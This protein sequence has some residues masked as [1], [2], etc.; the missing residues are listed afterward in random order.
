MTKRL[1]VFALLFIVHC[2]SF[3]AQAAD[4]LRAVALNPVVITGT[5][6]YHRADNSPV[7]VRVI[8]AEELQNAHVTSLQEALSRLT[9]HVTTHTNGMGTFINFNGIS[10]DYIVILE[11]GRRVS[12]DDRWDRFNMANVKRIEVFS[13]AASALY[14]SD[15]I[16]GVINIITDDTKST[17]AA[18]SDTK[19]MSHGRLSQDVSVDVNHGP[20][21][22]HTAYA[23]RQADGW[24]VNHYQAFQEG[25]AEVLKLTGRPMSAA[26]A[27]DNVSQKLE[28]RFDDRWS[29]YLRGSYYDYL[30]DRPQS[31]TYFTQ[32][33]SGDDYKYTERRAYTYDL[34]H[35]SYLYGGG[36]RWTPNNRTHVY[37]DVYSDNF[38]SK[39][40]Y[41]Q[42]ADKEAYD[43]T[44]KRTHYVSETLRGIFRLAPW[45]KLSAGAE[46]VQQSLSSHS[47]QI[48]FETTAT[49]NVFAQD[50][51]QI[52]GGLEAVAGLRYT[53]NDHFGSALTP[54][55][56][57]FYHTGHFRFR[58][59]YAGGYRTPTLSQLFATD[60]AKTT[61]RYTIN[62]TQLDPEKNHF[63]NLN[64]EYSNSWMSLSVS[65]FLNKIRDMINYRTM[66]TA[67]IDADQHLSQLR[68]E[69]WTTIRQRDNIDRAT[70]RGLSAQ[71]KL[72]LPYGLTLSG[73][74]TF[75]DSEATT[76]ASPSA[77]SPETKTPVDKSVRHVGSVALTWDRQWKNYHLNVNLNGHMQGRRYSSTYGYADAYSQWD[78]TTTHAIALR[79]FTLEPGLGVENLFNKRD[80]APWNSNFSTIN[81]GRSL[82]VSLRMK[83]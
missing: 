61:A 41:W 40:D 2:T 50:E 60:Q 63:F 26:Y 38:A 28:W 24:Q 25:D 55:V 12:G 64:A 44:R 36:A 75:T 78:L 34:H 73:G 51:L 57:L 49:Y 48:D 74:Y 8:T 80:T 6:T 43:E 54:N 19:V 52:V 83:Y 42:T 35:Q 65:G 56:G 29:V 13:G 15:A 23:H 46:L 58:A 47:D 81:P 67:E 1:A 70:L 30:T 3:I 31:A 77:P 9:T 53:Y 62:N 39:Y 20:F 69:G 4:S 11:N 71:L 66:T 16:A 18:L 27:S 68:E 5:G 14:G 45:N 72:L 22:S 33:K 79:H 17:V 21:S 37:L 76:A 82:V 10:D 32:K 7:A 59:S